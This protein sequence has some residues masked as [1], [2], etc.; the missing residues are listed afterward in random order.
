VPSQSTSKKSRQ[1]S[2]HAAIRRAHL[3]QVSGRYPV[4][5]LQG[6]LVS[7]PIAIV[8]LAKAHDRADDLWEGA[9]KVRAQWSAREPYVAQLHTLCYQLLAELA[10]QGDGYC[11]VSAPHLLDRGAR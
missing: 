1:S 2:A 11:A 6:R 3:G 4:R 7:T 9:V 8:T 10:D 5:S